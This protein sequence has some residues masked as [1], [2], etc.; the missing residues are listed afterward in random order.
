MQLL[1]VAVLCLGGGIWSLVRAKEISANYEKQYKDWEWLYRNLPFQ[2]SNREP[3]FIRFFGV[4]SLLV[5]LGFLVL[6]FTN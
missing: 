5:G 2:R 4:V 1:L 6:F 3:W